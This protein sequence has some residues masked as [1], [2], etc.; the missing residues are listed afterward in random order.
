MNN[1]QNYLVVLFK[2]KVRKKIINKFK[3]YKRAL[4]LYDKLTLE[5]SQVIFPKLYEN[6]KRCSFEISLI[7]PYSNVKDSIFIKD[8]IGRQIK[9]SLDNGDYSIS[10]I[11]YFN[12]EEE[13]LDYSTKLKITAP[14]LIKKYLTHDSLKLI[15]KLNNKVI[16]QNE[17]KLNL[18]TFKN[19]EDSERFMDTLSELF[20]NK[21]RTDCLLVKDY[22]TSQRKYLYDLLSINGFPKSYLQRHSTTHPSKK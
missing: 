10:K 12:T 19:D 14:T 9:I 5:S 21:K 1:T 8:D 11:S 7:C 3:T 17:N 15:S 22:S 13:F 20:I 16:I 18:F 4:S 6:G 2:N